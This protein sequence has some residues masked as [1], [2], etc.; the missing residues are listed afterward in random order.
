MATKAQGP[1]HIQLGGRMGPCRPIGFLIEK[2]DSP[3]LNLVLCGCQ[4][5]DT[6]G[7]RIS[8]CKIFLTEVRWER[9]E[10]VS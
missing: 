4:M 6:A 5:H 10:T 3:C 8:P 2:V 9:G 1:G 7:G